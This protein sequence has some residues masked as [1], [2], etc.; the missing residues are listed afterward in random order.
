MSTDNT[1]QTMGIM[2]L[3]VV[4]LH[5]ILLS[6]FNFGL[7]WIILK[8]LSLCSE[9]NF[10]TSGRF[11]WNLVYGT[12]IIQILSFVNFILFNSFQ[13]ILYLGI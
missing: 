2:K 6:Y 1:T 3:N 12:C 5:C 8:S 9:I 4:D 13:G 7:V 11:W 10:K